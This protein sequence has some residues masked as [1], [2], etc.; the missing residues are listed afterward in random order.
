[1][2]YFLNP[3][4]CAERELLHDVRVHLMPIM[5]HT[6]L[7]HRTQMKKKKNNQKKSTV[8]T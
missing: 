4:T 1:M 2:L 6:I 7:R 8:D 3:K 5:Y